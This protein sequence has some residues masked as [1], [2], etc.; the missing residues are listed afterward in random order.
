MTGARS[1]GIADV[2]NTLGRQQPHLLSNIVD[3]Q[4]FEAPTA[5][6]RTAV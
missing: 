2:L 6:A 1:L 4:I 3:I 5:K